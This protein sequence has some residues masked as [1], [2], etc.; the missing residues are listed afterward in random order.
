MFFLLFYYFCLIIEGSGRP[1]NIWRIRILIRNTDGNYCTLTGSSAQVKYVIS[2]HSSSS[3]SAT[4]LPVG[5]DK[6]E[7]AVVD[8][9]GEEGHVVGV[10][11]PV[12]EPHRLPGGDQLAGLLADLAKH[13]DVAFLRVA[14][15]FKLQT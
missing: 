11:D 14:Q 10:E 4:L 2:V 5:V 1:K 15:S 3:G 9:E 6:A 8:G 12:G 13:R 7:G